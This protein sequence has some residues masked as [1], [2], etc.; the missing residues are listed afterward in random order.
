MLHRFKEKWNIKSNFQLL[1]IF[2]VFSITGSAAL[3]VRKFVFH[4]VGIQPNTSL[5]IKVPL[6]IIILVPSYQFLLLIIGTLLGQYKF[7]LAYE[8][9]TVGRLINV[10]KKSHE[11]N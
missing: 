6:Y 7:F 9:K 2:F 3:V 10:N 8:K 11:Q 1:V 5:L 4:L